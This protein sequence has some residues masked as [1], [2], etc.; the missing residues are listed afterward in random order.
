MNPVLKIIFEKSIN[1]YNKN[2]NRNYNPLLIILLVRPLQK[3][4][5]NKKRKYI[6]MDCDR[7]SYDSY[8]WNNSSC[9]ICDSNIFTNSSIYFLDEKKSYIDNDCD[10]FSYA[11][12]IWQDD[13]Y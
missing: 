5:L 8:G 6:S 4:W 7:F 10:C 9:E 1:L 11:S 3:A 2:N 12:H 13:M